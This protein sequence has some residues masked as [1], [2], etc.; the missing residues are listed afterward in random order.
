MNVFSLKIR[1]RNHKYNKIKNTIC[2]MYLNELQ[3]VN[4]KYSTGLLDTSIN[5]L[6]ID[7]SSNPLIIVSLKSQTIDITILIL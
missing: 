5:W 7:I 4:Q 3:Y 1:Y 6:L 2:V